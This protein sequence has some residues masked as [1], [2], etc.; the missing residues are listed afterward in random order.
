MYTVTAV[1]QF[2]VGWY[3]WSVKAI[4]KLF[5][6]PVLPCILLLQYCKRLKLCMYLW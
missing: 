4:A 3:L 1:M 6:I 2:W 5:H